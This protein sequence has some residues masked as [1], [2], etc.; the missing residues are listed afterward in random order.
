VF[1]KRGVGPPGQRTLKQPV[2]HFFGHP[3]DL[4]AAIKVIVARWPQAPLHLLGMSS[5]NGLASSYVALHGPEVASLR[6]CSCLIG[7]ENYNCAF[8]PT[9]GNWLSRLVFDTVFLVTCKERFLRRNEEIL[10]SNNPA[11]Y[12]AGMAAKTLQELYDICM[13]HFSGYSDRAEGERRINPFHSD[14]NECMLSFCVPFLVVFTE[15]DPV[16]PG[17]PRS[18]WLDVMAKCESACVAI[19]PYGSH[20]GCYDSLRLTRWVD[21]LAVQWIDAVEAISSK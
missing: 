19:Y 10:R 18:S 21:K 7:G 2:F 5:G 16:A 6:S 11:A 12:D 17:G 8:M 15:D 1:E 13:E 14:T 3:S 20:L 9:R 4:H